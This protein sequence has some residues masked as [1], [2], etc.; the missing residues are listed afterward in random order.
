M[1]IPAG[2]ARHSKKT[3]VKNR[4]MNPPRPTLRTAERSFRL[5]QEIWV[6]AARQHIRGTRRHLAESA[7]EIGPGSEASIRPVDATP[8]IFNSKEKCIRAK[9]PTCMAPTTATFPIF[10]RLRKLR[11]ASKPDCSGCIDLHR[12]AALREKIRPDEADAVAGRCRG[13]E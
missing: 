1:E 13:R 5:H 3:S 2:M 6:E 9:R 11:L 4:R 8:P 10:N 7:R 12:R